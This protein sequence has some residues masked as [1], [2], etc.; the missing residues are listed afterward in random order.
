M[1]AAVPAALVV[2]LL[3][4]AAAGGITWSQH[5][6]QKLPRARQSASDWMEESSAKNQARWKILSSTPE[7]MDV[8]MEC[9][10]GSEGFLP[11][12]P[13]S[14]PP[15]AH[16]VA[17][18]FL[19]VKSGVLHYTLNGTDGIA[20]PGGGSV[21]I[22]PELEHT[23]WNGEPEQTLDMIATFAPPGPY[24]HFFRS[25]VGL[26]HDYGTYKQVPVLQWLVTFD[27]ADMRMAA[28]PKPVWNSVVKRGVVPLAKLAGFRAFEDE[29]VTKQT[30]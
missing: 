15:H 6:L 12:K 1:G 28:I 3:A 2:L 30:A 8:E 5:R 17:T 25:V 19:T 4:L 13:C 24:E 16:A 10:P 21:R 22:D 18:E 11:N 7:R 23:F 9:R 27:A 14:P 26:G 20:T 29:Y